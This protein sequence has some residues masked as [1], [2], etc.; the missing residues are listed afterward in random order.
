M[1]R[2]LEINGE[3]YVVNIIEWD[4]LSPYAPAGVVL[5][6]HDDYPQTAIGWQLVNGEWTAPR[7]TNNGY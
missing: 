6:A 4:G 3:G 7:E 5:V 2:Y 1:S